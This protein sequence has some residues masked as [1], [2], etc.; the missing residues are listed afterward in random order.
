[1]RSFSRYYNYNYNYYLRYDFEN[2]VILT[3][4]D[5]FYLVSDIRV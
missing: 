3:I 5:T 1:M 2:Y 4:F